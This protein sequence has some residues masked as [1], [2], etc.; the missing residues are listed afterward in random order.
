M[1]ITKEKQLAAMLYKMA[2][3]DGN[4]SKEEIDAVCRMATSFK[5]FDGS[6]LK[7]AF[8]EEM[9]NPSDL[10]A[11]VDHV[12]ADDKAKLIYACADIVL[13]DGIICLDEIYCLHEIADMMDIPVAMVS[14]YLLKVMQEYPGIRFEDEKN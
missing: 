7:I 4:V 14:Y 11:L 13:A 12:K 5:D 6:L 9:E 3:A 8:D 1:E 10:R 2:S